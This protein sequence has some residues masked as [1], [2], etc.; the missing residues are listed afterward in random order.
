LVP[1]GWVTSDDGGPAY[2]GMRRGEDIRMTERSGDRGV[3]VCHVTVKMNTTQ[4]R[5]GSRVIYS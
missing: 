4:G 1:Q 5:R 2:G 3:S